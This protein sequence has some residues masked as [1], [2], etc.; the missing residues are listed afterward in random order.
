MARADFRCRDA[1]GRVS[2]LAALASPNF[3]KAFLLV[4]ERE[5]AI[6]RVVALAA[7][8]LLPHP[9]VGCA[10]SSNIQIYSDCQQLPSFAGLGRGGAPS[11]RERFQ[12]SPRPLPTNPSSAGSVAESS[13][14]GAE[15]SA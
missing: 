8:L 2:C 5:Q 4:V 1:A 3:P 11:P 9:G 13:S 6:A 7:V 15:I 12:I 10:S 14:A